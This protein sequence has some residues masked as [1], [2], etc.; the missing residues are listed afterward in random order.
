[1]RPVINRLEK[2][3]V[4]KHLS[5]NIIN[6]LYDTV[7]KEEFKQNVIIHLQNSTQQEVTWSLFSL[8]WDFKSTEKLQ[9]GWMSC[10]WRRG[11]KWHCDFFKVNEF[12]QRKQTIWCS[13]RLPILCSPWIQQFAKYRKFLCARHEFQSTYGVLYRVGYGLDQFYQGNQAVAIATR[14]YCCSHIL[15][16]RCFVEIAS[17]VPTMAI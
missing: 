1:M 11:T 13:R 16:T 17:E 3:F 12:F 5:E 14:D 6:K 7:N 15:P 4:I 10:L 8:I 9:K 2:K